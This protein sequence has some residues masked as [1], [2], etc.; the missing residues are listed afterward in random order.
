MHQYVAG[1]V[2]LKMMMCM[3]SDELERGAISVYPDATEARVYFQQD[4]TIECMN[5]IMDNQAWH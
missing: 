5:T 3:L 2:A 1:L 4:V